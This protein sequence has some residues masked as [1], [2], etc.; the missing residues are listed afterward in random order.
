M[1]NMNPDQQPAEPMAAVARWL[2]TAGRVV[3][4]TGAGISAESGLPTF[5][6]AQHALWSRFQPEALATPEGFR[7]D[8]ALV[9]AWYQ[10]R[11]ALVARARPNAGHHALVAMER[12]V[13]EF[14]LVTQN[15]D[16]LHQ[17]A[18]SRRII[19]LHGDLMTDRCTRCGREYPSTVD[20]ALADEPRAQIPPPCCRDCGGLLRPAVVWFGEQLPVG[21]MESAAAAVAAC[22]ILLVIGTSGV[23]YPAASLAPLARAA[24]ARVVVVNPEP[25]PD[26]VATHLRGPAAVILPVLARDAFD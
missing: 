3:A 15:V 18:G 19:A 25:P 22:D 24:G 8:P 1:Q 5:R 12:A 21:A 16:G 20:P 23:V 2:S 14:T 10:W 9:W 4:L 17:A 11:R 26:D 13:A 7:R 6:G